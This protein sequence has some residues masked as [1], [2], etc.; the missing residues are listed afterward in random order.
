MH[1]FAFYLCVTN[2]NYFKKEKFP[3]NKTR[4]LFTKIMLL[5]FK[6]NV[7]IVINP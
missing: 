4:I 6:T 7:T 2:N 3:I 5:I 1:S